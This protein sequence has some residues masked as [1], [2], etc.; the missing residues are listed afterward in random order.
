MSNARGTILSA[1]DHG[2]ISDAIR[3]AEAETTGE[4]VCV[5]ARSSDDYFFPAAFFLALGAMAASLLVGLWIDQTW[6]TL[7]F[8]QFVATQIVAV[9]SLMLVIWWWPA[10]RIHLVPR[11]LRYLRA[12][13]A[14]VAQFLATNIHATRGRTGVLVFVSLAEHYAEVVADAGINA[15]VPQERWNAVVGHLVAHAAKDEIVE[16]FELVIAEVG[17]LLCAEFPRG[18]DDPNELEDRLVEI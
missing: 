4:I 7:R 3:K 6:H 11:R 1:A 5:L 9:G 13:R 15:R 12:H 14:A 17:T 8:W 18:K 10:L 2:R 16:G